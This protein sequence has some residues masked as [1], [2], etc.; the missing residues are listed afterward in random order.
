MC[1]LLT[2]ATLREPNTSNLVGKLYCSAIPQ[3]NA[4]DVVQP[5]SLD[6]DVDSPLPKLVHSMGPSGGVVGKTMHSCGEYPWG[7]ARKPCEAMKVP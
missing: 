6:A 2:L 5:R 7:T 3:Y 4:S 1:P